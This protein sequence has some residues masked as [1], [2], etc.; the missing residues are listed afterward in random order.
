MILWVSNVGLAGGGF[1]QDQFQLILAGAH[2]CTC[3]GLLEIWG[4]LAVRW[5]AWVLLYGDISF[6]S[7]GGITWAHSQGSSQIPGVVKAGKPQFTSTFQ[8]YPCYVC[9]YFN[10]VTEPTPDSRGEETGS[11]L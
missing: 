7:N 8:D 4:W 11:C 10:I 6:S 5:D 1:G 9:Y 3:G 2:S